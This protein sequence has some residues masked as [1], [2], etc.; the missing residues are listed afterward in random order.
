LIQTSSSI[1]N[2]HGTIKKK[3]SELD[4]YMVNEAKL[5]KV[6]NAEVKKL[7]SFYEGISNQTKDLT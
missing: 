5:F 2:D 4:Y 6:F 1:A 3:N 7:D